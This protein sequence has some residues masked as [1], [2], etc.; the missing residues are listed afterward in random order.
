MLVCRHGKPAD[1]GA[2][3]GCAPWKDTVMTSN[4]HRKQLVR[5]RMAATGE[6]YSVAYDHLQAARTDIALTDPVVVDVHGRHGQAVAFTPDGTQLVSGG[7]DT[8]VAVLDAATGAIEGELV[9]HD[10]VVNAVA[11]VAGGARVVSA[12]SDR[13]VR[14]WDL[15]S[16]SQLSVLEGHRDAVVALDLSPG[17]T[18]AATGGYD[19]RVRLWDLDQRSSVAEHRT[20]IR[21]VAA[22]AFVDD[23]QLVAAA[24]QGPVVAVQEAATGEAVADLDTGAPGVV[25]LAVA[26]GG[27]MLATAGYDGTV[28]LWDVGTWDEVRRL[29]AG[30]KVG[31]VCFSRDG[32]L[33][34]A[35]ASGRVVVWADDREEPIADTKLPISGVYGLAFSRDARRLA[36]TGADG[37]VRI[38]T[39]R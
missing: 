38:W 3:V 28:I 14:L 39:L 29:T 8:R 9:G 10:K 16:R 26:P 36:Q 11:V 37:Q 19:G 2:W 18:H 21:R 34:G 23:G 5:A 35:A 13:T 4:K 12:S 25:G 1:P 27:E 6:S 31:A 30:G 24:G 15:E 32:Q 7:Q 22:V 17:G 20:G 33:L